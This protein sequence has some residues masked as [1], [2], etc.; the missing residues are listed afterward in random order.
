MGHLWAGETVSLQL[1]RLYCTVFEVAFPVPAVWK[2]YYIP[3][4][5]AMN[6]YQTSVNCSFLHFHLLPSCLNGEMYFLQ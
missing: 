2:L 4:D 1:H 6:W 3:E 5:F